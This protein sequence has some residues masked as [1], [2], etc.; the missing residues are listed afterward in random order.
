MRR[1]SAT[2]PDKLYEQ[3]TQIAEIEGRPISNLVSYLLER[4][5]DERY[6]LLKQM[7]SEIKTDE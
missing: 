2:I 4:S 5:L 3:L 1:L 7:G 6:Q